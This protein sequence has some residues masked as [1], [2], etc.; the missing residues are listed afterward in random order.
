MSIGRP[1]PIIVGHRGASAYAPENTLAAF[2]R[3]ID[4]GAE[5]LEFDVRLSRDGV[6]V[7]I[8]DAT[9]QRTG[10]LANEVAEM[11]SSEL[12]GTDV[13]SW[14]NS[15][16]PARASEAFAAETVPTL[17]QTLELLREFTGRFYIE[18]KCGPSDAEELS[19]AVCGVIRDS[20]L[21]PQIVV[22][23]F[24]LGISPILKMSCSGVR[25]AALFAP[26]I[27]T[28]LRKEKYL[29]NIAREFNADELS[30]H[31][32]LATRKLM[33]KADAAGFPVTIWT[34]ENPRWVKRGIRIG[35]T[36]I[37]TNDPARLLA[38]RSVLTDAAG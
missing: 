38:R 25:T 3:A 19:K 20:P 29:V 28:M 22:K 2:R 1:L 23:S 10:G 26:Q 33:R 12:G 35:L 34:A 18:L 27:M 16:F 15:A 31:Y 6:P 32:S 11:T 13:G 7:V 30:M 17:R 5:G 14:F 4:D 8:H 21:L 24:H 36:A 9:L 37:I